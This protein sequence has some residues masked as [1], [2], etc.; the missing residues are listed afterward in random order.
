MSKQAEVHEDYRR[1]GTVRAGSDRAFGLV[2]SAV[3]ALVA[4]WPLVSGGEPRWWA[5]AVV[6]AL[7]P[8]ALLRPALLAPFN[9]LW[10]RFGLL[11]HRIVSPVILGL[12]FFLT[13]APIALIMRALGKDPLRLRMEPDA[14]TYWIERT[15]PGPDPA[16]MPKQF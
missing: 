16:T 11:L 4:G 6:V 15:P 9:R 12:L 10:F 7:L 8:M 2:F 13:I 14:S 5:L 1:R 3:F